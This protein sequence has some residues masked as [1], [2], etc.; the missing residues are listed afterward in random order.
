[1]EKPKLREKQF[2]LV[3]NGP[4]CGG[5]TTT[6]KLLV[7]K[8]GNIFQAKSDHIKWLISDYNAE[9]HRGIIHDMINQMIETALENGLSV[10]KEGALFEPEKYKEIGDKFNVDFFF[11]NVEASW[12]ILLERFRDRV[13]NQT[14]GKKISNTSEKRL[15]ELYE[16]Y[17]DSKK[18]SSVTFDSSKSNP[19][20]I[21]E[22][23][24]DY[25]K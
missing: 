21:V 4:S 23:I 6:I 12:D 9:K 2:F 8:Y 7:E 24:V 18:H 10:I 22:K 11:I 17:I 19:E 5:K 15:Q 20:E 3:V 14:E 16:M 25:L 1:M 13:N